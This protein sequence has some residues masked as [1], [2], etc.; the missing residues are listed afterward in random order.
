MKKSS[1]ILLLSFMFASFLSASIEIGPEMMNSTTDTIR[2]IG[3]SITLVSGIGFYF[4]IR[5]NEEKI[6]Q[7]EENMK[8]KKRSDLGITPIE[9]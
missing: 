6:E 7:D 9:G 1:V 5:Q 4:L 3:S 2:L 8:K